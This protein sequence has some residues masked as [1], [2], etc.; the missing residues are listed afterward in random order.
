MPLATVCFRYRPASLA[1]RDDPATGEKLDQWNAAILEQVN[2][3]GRYYLSSTRLR[4]RFALRVS[5]GN[6]R[7]TPSHV[8]GCWDALQDAAGRV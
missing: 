8:T 1:G 3:T 5:L 2:R 4:D 6:P 7:Q